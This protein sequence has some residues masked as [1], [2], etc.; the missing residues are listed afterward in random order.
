MLDAGEEERLGKQL[1]TLSILRLTVERVFANHKPITFPYMIFVSAF[2][3]C[4]CVIGIIVAY[5]NYPSY[6]DAR[7]DAASQV[8]TF[9]D[10]R[11]DFFTCIFSWVYYWG[12]LTSTVVHES[13]VAPLNYYDWNIGGN[14][15]H[16]IPLDS[17]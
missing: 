3:T 11:V 13:I 2:C 5:A 6:F 14:H 16:Y 1:T 12:T 4:V 17:L 8:E 15:F 10:I 9:S 7:R